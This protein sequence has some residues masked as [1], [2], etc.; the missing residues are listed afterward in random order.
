MKFIENKFITID[1]MKVRYIDVGVG[2]PILL[3][4]GGAIGSS[5]EIYKY[6]IPGLLKAGYRCVAFDQPGF[7]LSEIPKEESKIKR[8]YRKQVVNEFVE[9]LNLRN[10]VLLGHSQSG[11][12][13]GELL[14]NRVRYCTAAVFLCSGICLPPSERF[15]PRKGGL[16]DKYQTFLE[17]LTAE[18]VRNFFEYNLYDR[19]LITEELIQDRLKYCVGE[20][21]DF[22]VKYRAMPSDADYYLWAKFIEVDVPM[23]FVYGASD[24]IRDDATVRLKKMRALYPYSRFTFH[25]F[26]NCKHYPHWDQPKLTVESIVEF[27]EK[28]KEKEKQWLDS[29]TQT[30]MMSQ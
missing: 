15:K 8:S 13:V 4:H 19:S 1:G 14:L 22:F 17:E 5:L 6:I 2:R 25:L 23:M 9:K 11:G 16:R 20:L 12:A 30:Q 26:N 24:T 28:H 29:V 21:Y 18:D 7:G 10:V 27:L 3:L